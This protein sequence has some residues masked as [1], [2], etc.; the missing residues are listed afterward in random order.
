VAYLPLLGWRTFRRFLPA[1]ILAVLICSL[2]ALIGKKRK[3]WSFYNKPQSFIQGELPFIIGPMLATSLWILKW[4]YG[5]FKRF[6]MLNAIAEVIFVS[7]IT[8]VF[9]K[10]KLYRVVQINEFKFFLYFFYKAFL[11]YGFQYLFEKYKKTND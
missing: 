1:S 6:I 4:G 7:P 5:N 11:L 8:R 2:D 9:T 10:L 3:W